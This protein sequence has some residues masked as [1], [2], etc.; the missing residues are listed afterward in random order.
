MSNL[1]PGR[2]KWV[3]HMMLNK[4]RPQLFLIGKR[5]LAAAEKLTNALAEDDKPLI[6]DP[7]FFVVV[8]VDE[9]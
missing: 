5:A 1:V 9:S 6:A 7:T 8:E 3:H 2:T 4:C